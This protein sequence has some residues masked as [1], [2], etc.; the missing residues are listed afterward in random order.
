MFTT[1][2]SGLLIP[3]TVQDELVREQEV[4]RAFTHVPQQQVRKTSG[5][6]FRELI[7][8]G[9]SNAE[10]VQIVRAEFPN[11]VATNS[12][13]SWN[14]SQL[15]KFAAGQPVKFKVN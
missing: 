13:A 10:C 4:V 7:L 15:K 5:Q 12:D 1:T 11:S 6:R 2:N 3:V 8:M 14:R 9:K